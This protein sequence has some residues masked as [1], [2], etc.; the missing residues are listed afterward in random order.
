MVYFFPSFFNSFEFNKE[1]V[2][3]KLKKKHSGN[4]TALRG[5]ADGREH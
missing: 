2:F 3:P 4:E 1:D 5:R